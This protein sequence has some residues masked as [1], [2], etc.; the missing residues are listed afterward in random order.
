VQPD[1]G[2]M[3]LTGKKDVDTFV[4][5]LGALRLWDREPKVKLQPEPVRGRPAAAAAR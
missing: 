3:P 5:A 1:A 2:I 4:N